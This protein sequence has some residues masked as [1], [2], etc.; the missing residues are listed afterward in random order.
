M[1]IN[2][3]L[4]LIS[5]VSLATPTYQTLAQTNPEQLKNNT[6]IQQLKAELQQLKKEYQNK[7][8]QLETRLSEVEQLNEETQENIDDLAI[9]VSQQGNQKTAN[10]FNPAIGMILNGRWLKSS[11][12]FEYTLPGFFPS[13]EIGPG[14]QG[15]QLGESEFNLS[16]NVDDKFYASVTVAF[17]EEAE[18]EEAYIQTLSLGNGF[19]IKTGKFLSSIGYLSS[20]HVHADDFAN[21]PLPYE[22][23]LGGG[24]GDMGI[25]TTWLAATDLFW[26]SGVEFYRGDN[27][28][29]AGAG[30]SGNG[31]WTAFTHLGGDIGVSQSWR[32]GL[33][34]LDAQVGGRMSDDG[35]EFSGSSKLWIADF[36]Y[37]WSPAGNRSSEELK[38]Q[39]EYLSRDEKGYLTDVNLN[40]AFFDSNQ[41][42]W[43][44]EGVYRFSRQWRLG[45]RTSKLDPNHISEP[46]I[47]SIL[48]PKSNSPK[49]HSLMLDWTNSEF[50]RI[51][52]QFDNNELNNQQENVWILQ[53]I[54]AFGAHGAHGF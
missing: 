10:T 4:L 8:L 2:K 27:Y 42:G 26:E 51:R 38:I 21:R 46:F 34:Y 47:N 1:T 14:E 28:P 23:F 37:K 54:A 13:D 29:A 52:L 3:T 9:N 53:Y 25:Q 6:S 19:N 24:L 33:S 30:H 18:V 44:V 43:Y 36:I 48:D 20:K 31:L 11:D 32:A 41:S 5:M 12:S 15:F 17:G 39:A 22:A 40:N 7:I 50:S 35:S 45:L 16:A 49:Q